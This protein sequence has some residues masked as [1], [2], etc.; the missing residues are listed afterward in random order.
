MS[1]DKTIHITFLMS[2]TTCLNNKSIH[3]INCH[4]MEVKVDLSISLS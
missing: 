4:V 2:L 3:F 1:I